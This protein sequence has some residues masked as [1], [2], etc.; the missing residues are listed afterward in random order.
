[1]NG[2]GR[3]ACGTCSSF[4][5]TKQNEKQPV[6]GNICLPL[7]LSL[8]FDGKNEQRVPIVGKIRKI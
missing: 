6:T 5:I 7:Y 3:N 2:S 4:G 8:L 1:M